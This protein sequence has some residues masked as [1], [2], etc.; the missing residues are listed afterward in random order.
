MWWN[1][2]TVKKI[3]KYELYTLPLLKIFNNWFQK[4]IF[5]LCNRYYKLKKLVGG[6][7]KIKSPMHKERSLSH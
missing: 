4:L 6:K 5:L 2:F 1:D 3:N 7:K